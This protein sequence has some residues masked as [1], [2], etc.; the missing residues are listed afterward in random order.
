M[1]EDKSLN[2]KID[3]IYSNIKDIGVTAFDKFTTK[4][5]IRFGLDVGL[6]NKSNNP[7]PEYA[8][9][10]ASGFDLRANLEDG[11]IIL[12][13]LERGLIPTGLFFAI[14][15]YHELQVRPRSGLALKHGV[16]VLNTPGT[17][18]ADYRGEVGIILINLGSEDFKIEHGD[19][20]AQAVITKSEGGNYYNLI[21]KETLDTTERND[22]GFGHTGVK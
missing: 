16:T 14:P 2:E 22:G 8:T 3:D 13:P 11:P 12:K 19:R 9:E 17:V 5:H 7:N 18:D 15:L 10:N 6:V 20:I 1:S 4:H 21:Q